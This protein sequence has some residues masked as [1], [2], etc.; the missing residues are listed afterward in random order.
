MGV[1]I[2]VCNDNGKIHV[3][4]NNNGWLHVQSVII[5]GRYMYSP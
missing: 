5:T 4:S 3:Q 1:E 2:T